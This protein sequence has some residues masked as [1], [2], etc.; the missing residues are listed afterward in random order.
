MLVI[1]AA[2]PEMRC[3]NVIGLALQCDWGNYQAVD[4][5]EAVN[6]RAPAAHFHERALQLLRQDA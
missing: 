2:Y 6:H 1:V 3:E 5:T 4:R